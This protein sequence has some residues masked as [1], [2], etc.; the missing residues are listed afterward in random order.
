MDDATWSSTCSG[1][2][3]SRPATAVHRDA[4][5]RVHP[6]CAR[7]PHAS[8]CRDRVDVPPRG[9]ALAEE[10]FGDEVVWLDYQRPGFDMSRRVA[11]MLEEHPAARAVLLEKHGL[12][13]WGDTGQ[14]SYEATIE[15][16]TRSARVIETAANG[17]FG[18]GGPKSRSSGRR[19][20][21]LLALSLPALRGALLGDAEGV[22]LEVDRS[23]AAVA[24]ASST[25]TPEVS[26]IGA[27][28]PDH[29]I[30]TKHKPLVVD[31]DPAT[32]GPPELIEAFRRGVDEFAGWYRDYHERNLDDETRPFPID[33]A[34]PRVVLVP[35][36]GIVTTGSDAGRARFARTSTTGRSPSRTPP[37]RSA[38]SVR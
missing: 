30:N 35:G 3:P 34:G 17:R 16:V 8:G 7:R 12:V 2:A 14:E 27:P 13:T 31:F 38:A 1:R 23:A 26:Q 9:R 18:L 11:R 37:M 24:F 21:T 6:G 28:C 4:A 15:F 10:E 33:P 32:D 25:R 22:V 5:T 29:L 36:V 19:G 20:G